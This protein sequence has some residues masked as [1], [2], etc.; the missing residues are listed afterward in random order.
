MTKINREWHE[1]NRMPKNPTLQQRIEWHIGHAAN[2]TC[3][4]L[5]DKLRA[6]I[7]RFEAQ[8]GR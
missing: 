6:E 3:R 1:K 4:P 5:S 8:A 7:E 2:C